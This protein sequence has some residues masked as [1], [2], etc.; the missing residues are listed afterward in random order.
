MEI[1][2]DKA[3]SAIKSV[4]SNKIKKKTDNLSY[5]KVLF[6]IAFLKKDGDKIFSFSI[7]TMNLFLVY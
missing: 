6:V 3:V 5:P 7:F 1:V 2:S 4:P